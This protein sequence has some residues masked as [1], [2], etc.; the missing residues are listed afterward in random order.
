MTHFNHELC[1]NLPDVGKEEQL[2]SVSPTNSQWVRSE[3][4]MQTINRW[5]TKNKVLCDSRQSVC[6]GL[7]SGEDERVFE[8]IVELLQQMGELPSSFNI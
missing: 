4:N 8:E 5:Q 2:I 1:C 7:K 6:R 3:L